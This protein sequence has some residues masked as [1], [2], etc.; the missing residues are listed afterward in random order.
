MTRSLFSQIGWA[1]LLSFLFLAGC[2]RSN[3][4]ATPLTADDLQ[5]AHQAIP[6]KEISLLVRIGSSQAAILADVQKRHVPEPIDAFT[7][8]KLAASGAGPELIAALKDPAN[9]LTPKQRRVFEKE[10]AEHAR[11][12]ERAAAAREDEASAREAERA[13]EL[14]RRQTLVAQTQRNIQENEAR[15]TAYETAQK[16]YESQRKS[17]E[18]RI[19]SLQAEIN[20]KRSYGYNE[21]DLHAANET[22]DNLN[23]ELLHLTAPLR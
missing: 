20:R 21:A 2:L 6:I 16:N 22:L 3:P 17:L 8:E 11:Q 1:G 7:E 14:R 12:A 19:Q 13:A 10:Q 15:A 4:E 18:L 9:A 23:S 5:R